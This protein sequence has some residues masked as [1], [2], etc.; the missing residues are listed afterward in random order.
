MQSENRNIVVVGAGYGGI[1]AAL[2][3]AKL[4]RFSSNF[5]IHLVD[6]NPFHTLKTR[7]HE[8]AVYKREVAIDIGRII[9]K[10]SIVFHLG[11]VSAID[12]VSSTIGID[13]QSLQYEYMILALGSQANYYKIP[14]LQQFAFPLQSVEDAERIYKHI[15]ELCAR[16]SSE[17]SETERKKMLRFVVGGGGLS[18]IEFAGELVDHIYQCIRNYHIKTEEV[19]IIVVEATDN[20]LST[21]DASLRERI[22][23]RLT[24]KDII[25]Y[26]STRIVNLTDDAVSLSTGEVLTTQTLIWTGGIRSA[27]LAHESGILTDSLDRII[28]DGFLRSVDFPNIYAIGDNALIVNPETGKPVPAAAQFA[29]QQGRLVANNIHACSNGNEPQKYRP[30]VLGE[31]ISL[32]RHLAVG[33]L[34]LPIVRKIKFI[35]FLGRLL[36]TAV[37]EKHVFLLRKESRNWIMY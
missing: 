4:F 22:H 8:A 28:V 12:P 32:G 27:N 29:L 37:T 21:I 6:K 14:G 24:K 31:V 17:V 10:H 18:G 9:G 16:A 23:D 35:G 34:A 7:L 33:W 26:T 3:L 19:N 5:Q 36:K 13:N 11:N 1:T 30:K 25:I 20:I 2:R 15:S